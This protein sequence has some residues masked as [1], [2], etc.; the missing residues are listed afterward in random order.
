MV[1]DSAPEATV[2]AEVVVSELLGA[3]TMLYTV[4]GDTE[5]VSKVDA[6]DFHKPGENIDLAFNINDAH[7]FDKDS[8]LVIK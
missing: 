3:E 7:F 1:I 6:R 4:I 5:F 8:E 2:H